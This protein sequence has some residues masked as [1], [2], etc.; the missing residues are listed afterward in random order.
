MWQCKTYLACLEE[1]VRNPP[2]FCWFQRGIEYFD[3]RMK[4]E[5]VAHFDSVRRTD[6][7]RRK[8]PPPSEILTAARTL[9]ARPS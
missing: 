7:C 1:G 9:T 4:T 3:L 6:W 8:Q 2:F 5:V